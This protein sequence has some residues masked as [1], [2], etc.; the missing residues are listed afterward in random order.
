MTMIILGSTWDAHAIFCDVSSPRLIYWKQA[1][2]TMRCNRLQKNIYL[3]IMK[4]LLIPRVCKK[5]VRF[6]VFSQRP[7]LVKNSFCFRCEFCYYSVR[8]HP[9]SLFSWPHVC[10]K[11][12][13]GLE[14]AINLTPHS[15][16]I[17]R[18][19]FLTVTC[20]CHTVS[21]CNRN[22]ELAIIT[23]R[24]RPLFYIKHLKISSNLILFL[25]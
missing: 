20:I 4:K 5:I 21:Y 23:L 2:E 15:G 8:K 6:F 9:P 1:D 3:Y 17:W 11:L 12:I 10:I 19:T 16:V 13:Y 18:D 25:R 14:S 22:V 7:D 24:I